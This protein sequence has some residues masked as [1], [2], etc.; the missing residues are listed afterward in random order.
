MLSA[1]YI[2]ITQQL[3]TSVVA[4]VTSHAPMPR[5]QGEGRSAV[6]KHEA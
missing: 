6:M 3:L 4:Q 5:A 1:F 2:D